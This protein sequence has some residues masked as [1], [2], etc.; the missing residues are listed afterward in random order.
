MELTVYAAARIPF[1]SDCCVIP[2]VKPGSS[3][4]TCVFCGPVLTTWG[5][6]SGETTQGSHPSDVT[7]PLRCELMKQLELHDRRHQAAVSRSEGLQQTLVNDIQKLLSS[8]QSLGSLSDPAQGEQNTKE[9]FSQ[10]QHQEGL[11]S[12]LE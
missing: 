11:R 5:D 12:A 10:K 6:Y 8:L 4:Y 1:R 7:V 2:S 9:S 3:A